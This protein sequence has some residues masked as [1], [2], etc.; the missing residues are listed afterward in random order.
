M[1]A[2]TD[3]ENSYRRGITASGHDVLFIVSRQV[4][5]SLYLSLD[6]NFFLKERELYA[7]MTRYLDYAILD[8]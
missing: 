7:I 6:K 4:Q 1:A 8:E 2:Y 3:A 5:A